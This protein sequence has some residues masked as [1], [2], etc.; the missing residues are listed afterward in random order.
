MPLIYLETMAVGV[1]QRVQ[2]T[3]VVR[4]QKVWVVGQNRRL[5]GSRKKT[6]KSGAWAGIGITATT[7]PRRTSQILQLPVEKES[8]VRLR[9][10]GVITPTYLS[11][12]SYFCFLSLL[13]KC[14]TCFLN[15]YKLIS[16]KDIHFSEQ[17]LLSMV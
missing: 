12:I 9:K 3:K 10:N 5:C 4:V 16:F 11:Y 13:Q 2:K 6:T 7:D 1:E 17:L 15:Y 8:L 14:T